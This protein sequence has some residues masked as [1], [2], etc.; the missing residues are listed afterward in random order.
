MCGDDG[1]RESPVGRRNGTFPSGIPRFAPQQI[2]VPTL[3]AFATLPPSTMKQKAYAAA[4]V[5][6]DLGNRVKATLPQLLASTHRSEVLGKVGGFGGLFALDVKKHRQPVLVSSVDGVG[7][8]LK[9]AFA[10]DRHDTIGEDLVNHCVN[11]IA[12]LGAEP[13][14]FLDYLG[15]GKLQPH[16]FTEII[17][18]FTRGC[19][20]NNCALVGGETAQMPGFYQAGEYDVSGTI[21]G[22][23]EK[24]RMLNGQKSV[25]RGDVV[26]GI[27]ASGLHTN[28]YSLARKI[29][30]ETLKLKPKSKVAELGGTIGD[31]LL[32]VH[33]TYGPLVQALLKRFNSQLSTP[34]SQLPIKAFAHITGGGFVDNV[35]RTL[36]ANCD[37][38]I[39]K[40]SWDML[41]IFKIIEQKS[42]VPEAELYQV[43]NM[44]IGMTVTAAAAHADAV[45][46]A[47]RAAKHPAWIIGEVV[48]GTG[49]CRVE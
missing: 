5:D 49:E 34:S 42:G 21:V 30:F 3:P 18:G 4:G 28:G 12:V 45:L 43:F 1:A 44:G 7:T 9:I 20:A 29:F 11:D 15:T 10:M 22:V 24:S 19:A 23:V 25:K 35:P 16:V 38:V 36:P 48:K 46:R 32:K 39:R 8:K 6:I 27:G 17:K 40:G 14:F 2:H 31:E 33:V 13:L 26:I 41:P 37:V 47:I